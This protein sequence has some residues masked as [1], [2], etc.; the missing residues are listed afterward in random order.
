MG[1]SARVATAN[2]EALASLSWPMKDYKALVEQMEQVKGIPQVPGGYYTWRNV[3]NA[4]YDITTNT[5][6]NN[7][8][9]R[10]AL[11]DK[12]YYINAEIDYKRAEFG[13][14]LAS[15]DAAETT[16]TAEEE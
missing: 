2:K 12:V 9:A 16:E 10:E 11:M 14:P 13:L 8:T 7:T 4:F 6:T 15:D 1:A 5:A 3:N